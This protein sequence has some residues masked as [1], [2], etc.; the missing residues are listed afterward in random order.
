MA[1][2]ARQ[3][4]FRLYICLVTISIGFL[5]IHQPD[6]MFPGVSSE[7]HL[8]VLSWVMVG[9]SAAGIF[10]TVLND[11]LDHRFDWQAAANWRDAG[12]L[13]T[14][15]CYLALIYMAA[16]SGIP[17]AHDLLFGLNA[18]A[19]VWISIEDVRYRYVIPHQERESVHD[20]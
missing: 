17:S 18:T 1:T 10:D 4:G 6:I 15:F 3:I 13:V 20:S 16:R 2:V 14:A 8:R 9:C 11:I 5:G 7:E 19:C 12:Y